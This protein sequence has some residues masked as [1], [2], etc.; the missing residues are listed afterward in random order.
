[1]TKDTATVTIKTETLQKVVNYLTS[2]PY[3]QVA[4]LIAEVVKEAQASAKAPLEVTE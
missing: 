3:A 2:Q 4:D 1:M